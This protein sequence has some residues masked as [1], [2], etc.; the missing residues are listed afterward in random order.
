MPYAVSHK[1]GSKVWKVVN[2]ETGRILGTHSSKEKA[3]AQLRAVYANT[4]GK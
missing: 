1:P 4:G 2:K 3:E